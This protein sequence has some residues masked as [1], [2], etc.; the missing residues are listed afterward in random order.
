MND[1]VGDV[2]GLVLQIL[3]SGYA[4]KTENFFDGGKYVFGRLSG[5]VGGLIDDVLALE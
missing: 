3:G 1:P 4:R 5:V 2:E